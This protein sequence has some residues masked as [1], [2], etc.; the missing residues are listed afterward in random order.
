MEV[1]AVVGVSSYVAVALS[2]SEWK[3][4]KIFPIAQRIGSLPQSK[5]PPFSSV[6]HTKLIL[7]EMHCPSLLDSL[8]STGL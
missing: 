7:R 5:H 4:Q 2:R 1:A 8:S 3:E 6:L